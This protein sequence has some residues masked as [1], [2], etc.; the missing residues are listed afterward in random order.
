MDLLIEAGAD[1]NTPYF[2]ARTGQTTP[3]VECAK[4]GTSRIVSR[5]L[6]LGADVNV[7]SGGRFPLHEALEYKRL[8]C[9][10]LLVKAGAD[11]NQQNDYSETPMYRAARALQNESVNLLLE[12]GADVNTPDNRG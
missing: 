5:L 6:E 4:R 8:K 9:A 12:H 1:V 3:L 11:V 2:T 10:K 7:G